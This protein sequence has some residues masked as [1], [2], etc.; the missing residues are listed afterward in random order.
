MD[1]VRSKIFA[2]WENRK[3]R[4]WGLTVGFLLVV[5]IGARFAGFAWTYGNA[6]DQVA[7]VVAGTVI[8]LISMVV[9]LRI[10]LVPPVQTEQPEELQVMQGHLPSGPDYLAASQL[11]HRRSGRIRRLGEEAAALGPIRRT[12]F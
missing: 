6:I 5:P 8:G 11:A 9:L 2:F 7:V 3:A 4:N 10:W 1:W 12:P